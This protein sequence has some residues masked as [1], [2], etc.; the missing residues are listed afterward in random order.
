ME[1]VN[2]LTNAIQTIKSAFERKESRGAHSREDYKER[3]DSEWMKHS[4]TWHKNLKDDV[5]VSYRP[6]N[7]KTLDQKEVETIKPIQR[8]Y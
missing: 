1:L 5:T 8:T 3:N 6:V 4:L 2:L 7:L